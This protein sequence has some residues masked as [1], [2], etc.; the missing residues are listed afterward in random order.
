MG[1]ADP[2]GRLL[3]DTVKAISSDEVE[4]GPCRT[5]ATSVPIIRLCASQNAPIHDVAIGDCGWEKQE[6]MVLST[7]HLH[8]G[9]T[10][11]TRIYKDRWQIESFLKSL[12]QLLRVKTFVGTSPTR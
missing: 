3:R 4:S 5:I 11:V 10:T 7:N 1:T 8:L 2:A 6:E 9:A 12:K